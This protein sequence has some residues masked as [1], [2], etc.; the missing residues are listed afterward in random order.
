MLVVVETIPVLV[1][2]QTI[3]VLVVLRT[4]PVLVL[5][6][7]ISVLVVLETIP[8]E[9]VLETIPVLVVLRVT[10]SRPVKEGYR[11]LPNLLTSFTTIVTD[12]LENHEGTVSIALLMT[13]MA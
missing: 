6:E 12:A 2:L 5:L 10:Q 3:P 7:T 9:V 11:A 8:V 4:I 1:V 13:S